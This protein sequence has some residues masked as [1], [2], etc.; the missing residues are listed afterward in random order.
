MIIFGLIQ[1]LFK[2]INKISFFK[3]KL[4]PVQINRFRFGYFEKKT[5]SNRFGLIFPVCFGFFP[6]FFRF[7]FGSVFFDFRLI[8]PNRLVFFKILIGLIDFFSRFD[9]FGYFFCFLGFS[10]FFSPLTLLIEKYF[11]KNLFI[12]F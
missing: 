9:F 8:K 1:F 5:G 3:K 4:K 12:I 2:K 7:G 11:C 10:V 6:N